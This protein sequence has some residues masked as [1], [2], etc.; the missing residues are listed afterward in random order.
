MIPCKFF[1]G[2]YCMRGESCRYSHETTPPTSKP[3]RPPPLAQ[4]KAE[5][6]YASRQ[7]TSRTSKDGPWREQHLF[8]STESSSKNS[9]SPK[10]LRTTQPVLQNPPAFRI[11]ESDI[12][13][14]REDSRA[15]IPCYHHAR[16]N[17]RNGSA[18]PYSHIEGSEQKVGT[19]V[20]LE[21]EVRPNGLHL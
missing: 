16:G 15:Q 7:V 17:C 2:G 19:A 20:D 18:C 4:R 5:N 6:S 8:A 1:A 9:L 13:F 14:P 12:A 10:P 21:V 3:T 11:R